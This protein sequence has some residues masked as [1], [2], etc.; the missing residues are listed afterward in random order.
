MMCTGEREK[1]K[2]NQNSFQ[3]RNVSRECSFSNF[4]ASTSP[5]IPTWLGLLS[6]IRAP[7]WTYTHMLAKSIDGNNMERGA[8]WITLPRRIVTHQ[9]R[10]PIGLSIYWDMLVHEFKLSGLIELRDW[11]LCSWFSLWPFT[12]THYLGEDE[13]LLLFSR[14]P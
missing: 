4:D 7:L 2:V 14:H 9:C 12:F 1:N 10:K 5:A 11:R 6:F 3:F 8:W 13:L